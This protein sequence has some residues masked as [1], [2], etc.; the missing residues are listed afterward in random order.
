MFGDKLWDE[1]DGDFRPPPPR[2]DHRD[3]KH[4]KGKGGPPHH[5]HKGQ[6]G[7]GQFDDQE[8]DHKKHM[9]FCPVLST[10]YIIMAVHFVYFYKYQEA[11]S[12]EEFLE[13]ANTQFNSDI[14]SRTSTSAQHFYSNMMGQAPQ[15][16]QTQDVLTRQMVSEPQ[17]IVTFVPSP[18]IQPVSIVREERKEEE[19]QM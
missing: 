15:R 1:E 2:G 11:K 6:H 9:S 18:M 19:P 14:E 17:N 3:G 13:K 8:N 7:N 10:V 16:R 12:D 4:C 5:G